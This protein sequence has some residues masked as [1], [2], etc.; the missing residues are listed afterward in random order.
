MAMACSLIAGRVE[1]SRSIIHP[2]AEKAVYRVVNLI[3]TPRVALLTNVTFWQWSGEF[4]VVSWLSS[5][6]ACALPYSFCRT[7]PAIGRPETI[8]QAS[9]S[10][11]S[12]TPQTIPP[13]SHISG[14]TIMK[15]LSLLAAFLAIAVFSTG[16]VFAKGGHSGGHGGS[17]HSSSHHASTSH[18][19][20]HAH[21]SHQTNA[22]SSP[23]GKKHQTSN[24]NNG[25]NNGTSAKGSTNPATTTNNPAVVN[26]GL[27]H[28]RGYHRGYGHPYR[29]YSHRRRNPY[30]RPSFV[31]GPDQVVPMNSGAMNVNPWAQISSGSGMRGTG[32]THF[33]VTADSNPG[34]FS[35]RPSV[36]ATGALS[37]APAAGQSGMATVTLVL[38]SSGM[39]SS[40][41][42]FH[43]TVRPA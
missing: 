27:A 13:F 41:Q 31:K 21:S 3:T 35:Q 34:L 22:K 33:I 14:V 9:G 37:F 4:A 11:T 26:N 12:D 2:F 16:T 23:H 36:S 7:R 43:I 38:R 1:A 24:K 29:H 17:H 20:S 40:P 42:T 39:S 28:S 5:Q 10:P 8:E 32:G 30:G 25:N 15:R 6:S 19:G 18:S